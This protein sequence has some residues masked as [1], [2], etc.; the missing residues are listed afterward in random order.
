MGENLLFFYFLLNFCSFQIRKFAQGK[1][2]YNAL[3]FKNTKKVFLKSFVYKQDLI[4][5]R[6]RTENQLAALINY[7]RK[8]EKSLFLIYS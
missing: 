1:F 2:K 5:V 8:K 7:H 4:S 3:F 6:N